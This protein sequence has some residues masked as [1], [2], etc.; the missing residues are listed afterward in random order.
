[1]VPSYY[2][3]PAAAQPRASEDAEPGLATAG[4]TADV[5]ASPPATA[6]KFTLDDGGDTS[7]RRT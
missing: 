6:P 7:P 3:P 2:G 5:S 1:M 4:A